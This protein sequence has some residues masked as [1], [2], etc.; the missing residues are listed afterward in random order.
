MKEKTEKRIAPHLYKRQHKSSKGEWSTRFYGIFVDWKGKRRRFPLGRYLGAAKDKLKILEGEN[1]K[2]KDFDKESRTQGMTL[3]EWGQLYFKSKVAPD[4]RSVERER[5]SFAKLEGS[6]GK[7]PLKEIT[8][9]RVM[10]YQAKRSQEPIVRR[11]KAVTGSKIAF[12]TINRELAFLRYLLNLAVDDGIIE[13]VPR[14]KLQS[15]KSRKRNRIASEDEYRALLENMP[16]HAQRVL[17]GLYET[18]MRLNEIMHLPWGM[19][20][21]KAGMIRLPAEYV[22]EK[23]PRIVPISGELREVLGELRE[24]QKK[25][26]S[27]AGRVFTRDGKAIKSIRTAFELAKDKK[28]IDNLRLHDFRHTAITR[29]ATIGIPREIVMAAAGHSSVQIHDGYVNVKENHIRD[30]FG[31]TI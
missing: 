30:A 11:G 1:V 8:R 16:R 17:I 25:A 9:S 26:A 21:L 4:K 23:A 12:P 24:E 2:E 3:S 7:L 5:R 19:V 10:E 31:L 6:F 29:W 13:T 15:E 22:K 18:A 27:I 20:D 14:M 28:G